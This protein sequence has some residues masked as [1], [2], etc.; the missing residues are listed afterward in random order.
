MMSVQHAFCCNVEK[1]MESIVNDELDNKKL[2]FKREL[3]TRLDSSE[4]K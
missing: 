2:N 4:E 3:V 1:E